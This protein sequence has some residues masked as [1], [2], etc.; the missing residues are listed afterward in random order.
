MWLGNN[1]VQRG[2]EDRRT[3][4][5]LFSGSTISPVRFVSLDFR[6]KSACREEE[7][8]R[9]IFASPFAPVSISAQLTNF[10]NLQ[11][12]ANL[13]SVLCIV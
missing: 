12:M 8:L 11:L 7:D 3:P 1:Q 4:P 6:L 5:S 2:L 10:L 13:C 9:A